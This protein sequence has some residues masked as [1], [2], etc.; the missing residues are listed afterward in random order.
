MGEILLL[1][2]VALKNDNRF[3]NGAGACG[4]KFNDPFS[5][6][7]R[8]RFMRNSAEGRRIQGSLYAS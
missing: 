5:K 8:Y 3:L 4:K 7:E 2:S 1:Q 6:Q